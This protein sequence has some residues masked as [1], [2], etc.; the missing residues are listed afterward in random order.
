MFFQYAIQVNSVEDDSGSQPNRTEQGAEVFI[1]GPALDTEVMQGLLAIEAALIHRFP[2]GT[3]A[4]DR[5]A[6]SPFVSPPARDH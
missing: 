5:Q 6:P 2:S 3:P 4:P 1:E